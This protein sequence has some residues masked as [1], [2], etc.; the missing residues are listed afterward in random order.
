M[1]ELSTIRDL[2]AI[3]GVIAGFS[4]YVLTVRNKQKN[5]E[6][7]LE[8]RKLSIYTSL[9]NIFTCARVWLVLV[10]LCGRSTR[11]RAKTPLFALTL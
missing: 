2:V 3:F 6:L 8:S 7:A 9:R 5:Q 4:Y 1:I 10:N 11:I